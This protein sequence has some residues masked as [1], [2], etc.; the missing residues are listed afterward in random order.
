MTLIPQHWT[1]TVGQ[2][3]GFFGESP[4]CMTGWEDGQGGEP[5]SKRRARAAPIAAMFLALGS[6]SALHAGQAALPAE[7]GMQDDI[8]VTARRRSE[9]VQDVPL[10]VTALTAAQVQ[11]S[12]AMGLSQVQQLAPSLQI[13]GTNVRNT[14]IN[15]RGLGATPAFASPGLEYGVGIYVDQVYLSRPTQSAFDLY[16]IDR[17]EVIRGPQGTLFGKNTTAGAISISTREPQFTPEARGELSVGNYN[18]L[19]A[20]A[21][22]SAPLTDTLALRLSVTDTVREKGSVE[23]VRLGTRIHDLYALGLRGQLLFAPGD[24]FRARLIGDYS[25]YA[26]DCCT[27]VNSAF[28]TTRVDGSVLPN[29]FLIR[30][31]RFGYVP[32]PIDPSARQTDINRSIF[33]KMKTYG[34]TLIADYD[35]GPATITSVTGW[36]KLQFRPKTDGDV[37]G[38]DIFIDAGVDEDQR[39]FSQELRI[40]SNGRNRIDYVAGLYYFDQKIED[41]FFTIYGPDAALWILGPGPGGVGPSIGGQAALNGLTSIGDAAIKTRSYAAFGEGTLHLGPFDL[42]AGLRYTHEKKTGTFG[43]VQDGPALTPGEI[44]VGAQAIRNA[45]AANIPIYAAETRENNLS[46]RGTIALHPMDGMMLYATYARGYKSGGLNLNATAAPRVI[47]PEKVKAW[48]AGVKSQWLDRRLTVNLAAYTQSVQD[49]QSQ[50]IDTS[51]AQV[52]YIANVG[53]VRSRGFEMEAQLRPFTGLSLFGSASYTDA[54]YRSYRNAPCPVEYLNLQSVCDLSGRPLPG[55][56]KWSWSAGGEGTL[57]LAGGEIYLNADYAHRSG[58][59]ST[60]NLAIDSWIDGYGIANARLGFRPGGGRFDLSLFARN[61]FDKTY[62]SVVNP[63]AF[64]TGQSTA[65]LGDPR[66]YGMT[67]K[68]SF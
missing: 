53:K 55:V 21:S 68:A 32:L 15:I 19:Q 10:A 14:N 2:V 35:L 5:M 40:A 63:S 16:D 38:L 9:R 49:Y 64:N 29:N 20:R 12:G 6:G 46:G 52:A 13:T 7:A 31:A 24:R 60:Y 56:S 25:D 61:L 45:F 62:L 58:F 26:Q 18:F 36:R 8:V 17:V 22:G 43:Q 33:V 47:D 28:R 51:V 27:G 48:E 44:A 1:L 4:A 41:R 65:I 57:P 37:T 30:A 50:Q 54:S 42:T 59:Y 3:R 23:N 67:L 11:E 66:F 34:G 39:Q